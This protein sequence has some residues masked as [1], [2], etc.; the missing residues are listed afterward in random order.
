[1]Q[2]PIELGFAAAFFAYPAK[3]LPISSLSNITTLE[4]T[5]TW[6]TTD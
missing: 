4:Y 2:T 6:R 5:E 3:A 1:M